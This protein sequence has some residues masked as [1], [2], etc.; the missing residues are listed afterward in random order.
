MIYTSGN[1]QTTDKK[2]TNKKH[3]NW[4]NAGYIEVLLCTLVERHLNVYNK[5]ARIFIPRKVQL[6]KNSSI[7]ILAYLQLVI[8]ILITFALSIQGKYIYFI[9]PDKRLKPAKMAA[10]TTAVVFHSLASFCRSSRPSF[11]CLSLAALA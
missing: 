6:K 4:L 7:M 9:F 10:A 5:W 1:C 3:D 2:K 11:S 8:T